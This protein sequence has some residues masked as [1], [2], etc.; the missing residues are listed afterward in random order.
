MLAG[1]LTAQIPLWIAGKMFRWKLVSWHGSPDR[2]MRWRLSHLLWAM[3]ATALTIA[4]GRL[5]L[6][7]GKWKVPNVLDGPIEAWIVLA[8]ILLT[9]VLITV[10]SLWIAFARAW[11]M[12]VAIFVWLIYCSVLTGAEIAILLFMSPGAD[13]IMSVYFTIWLV[14]FTQFAVVYG[15]LAIFRAIGFQ[16]IRLPRKAAVV[17]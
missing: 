11:N 1:F 16:F 2:R 3:L 15:A 5:I 10:P 14:N 13:V 9:N 8:V 12:A 4:P 17:A 7:R 6:P